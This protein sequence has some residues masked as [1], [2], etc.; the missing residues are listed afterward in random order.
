MQKQ[1]EEFIQERDRHKHRA[2]AEILSGLVRGAKHWSLPAQ[3][4]LWDWLGSLLP[5]IFKEATPD[6]QP[7]WQMCVEYMLHQRDPRRL[8]PL[9][10]HVL[11]NARHSISKDGGSPWEQSKAQHLLRGIIVS[12]DMK[13]TPWAQEFIDLY[14]ENFEHDFVEVRLFISE[15]LTDLE[16]LRVHP[17]FSSVEL[18]LQDCDNNTGS[19][20]ARPEMYRNRLEKLSKQLKQWRMERIPTSQGTS[21]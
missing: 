1:V 20:L 11:G 4:E 21:Q 13:F 7:A 19:L 14:D 5:R 15:S 9:L 18:F 17:S 2:A 6:S 10:A 12:A 16:L 3:N 8:K